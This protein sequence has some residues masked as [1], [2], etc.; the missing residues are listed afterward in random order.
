MKTLRRIAVA[1]L[2]LSA[3]PHAEAQE[4]VRLTLAEALERARQ[5][6]P[7]LGGLEDL[8][9]AAA[10]GLRGALAEKA[11]RVDV[12]ASYARNSDVDELT[13]A[14][15]GQPPRTL[16]PNIPDNYRVHLGA[17]L[18]LYTGGRIESAVD[19][20]G[21]QL[22]AAGHDRVGG[23]RDLA[24]ETR[25][26]YWRLVTSRAGERVLAESVASYEAHLGDARNRFEVGTVARNE[27]LAV[28]VERD[29]AELTRLQ[30]E[31]NAEVA[32]ADLV[33][34]TGLPPG[35]RVEPAEPLALPEAPV[36]DTEALVE[37]AFA[38]RPELLAFQERI[39]AARANADVRR[40]ASRPQ[41]GLSL[42]YDYA[43]PNTRIL[44]LE[45]EFRSTWTAGLSVSLHAFDG[46]RTA[47]ATAEAEARADALER[48]L[49]DVRQRLRLEVTARLL[50]LR[51]ARA[52][53]A[54]ADRNLEAA[55]ENRRVAA[56]RYGEG[57][58]PSSELLDAETA[59]LRA[60]LD[61]TSA[62][63]QVHV[64]LANLDR[65]VGR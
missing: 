45:D 64:A 19:A 61:Q 59:L 57:V 11:P 50:E 17:T 65:A 42:G 23:E 43:N 34:L 29:R 63:T 22:A 47:A 52:A 15:P 2:L 1:A 3:A 39:A 35:A 24:R 10:A 6:S 41:V 5:T 27:V 40:A 16:F 37:R 32:N 62:S 38:A 26:A 51:T 28:Q 7:S 49:E 8:E 48:Q 58:I 46:G 33:R 20:A 36:E 25:V 9:A 14:L 13:I 44:P 12:G 4:T 18:P 31:S 60:G 55:R 30:A 56:D 53:L 54:V 21:R